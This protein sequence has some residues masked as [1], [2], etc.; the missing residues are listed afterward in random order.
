MNPLPK[1]PD[2][3]VEA[4]AAWALKNDRGL[5]AAEQDEF[6]QWLAVSAAHRSAYAEARWGWE[7][8]DRLV[9]LQ[10]SVHA[11]PDPDLLAPP[12]RRLLRF[13]LP[14]VLVLAAAVVVGLFLIRPGAVP[15]ND[16]IAGSAHTLALIEQRE[17]SDGSVIELNRGAVVTEHFTAGQRLVRLVRGEAH[18]KVAKDAARPFVV[19]AAGVAVRA[20]GTAFNVRL[21][22]ASVEVLVTE[23]RVQVADAVRGQSLLGAQVDGQPPVLAAGQSATVDLAPTAVPQVATVSQAEIEQRLAWQPRLLD[24]TD[25]PM[26]EIVAEFNRRNPVRLILD[27]AALEQMRLSAAFRSDNVDGFVRLM[28]SD[29]GLR[30]E[31]RNNGEI[32]LRRAR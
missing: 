23:G 9:G 13:A 7:E 15:A 26:P 6:S 8:L 28:E 12:R 16:E 18:F 2:P 27:D 4:A 21:G 1:F 14:A 19:E 29:F 31:W 24:F 32:L 25:T 20:V 3:I 30:A 11:V 22:A 5:T 10:S 17:L